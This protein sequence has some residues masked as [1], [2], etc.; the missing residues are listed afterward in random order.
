MNKPDREGSTTPTIMQSGLIL[1]AVAAICTTLVALTFYAT[2]GRI[3][4]NEQ[5]YL[6]QSLTPVLSGISFDNS[7]PGSAV[8]IPSPHALPGSE[9][10]VIYRALNQDMPVAAVFVVTAPDG[11]SGTVAAA[12]SGKA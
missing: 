9:N 2:K 5:A 7:L 6:E 4:A 11:F 3:A 8:I 12:H 1:A 10:A